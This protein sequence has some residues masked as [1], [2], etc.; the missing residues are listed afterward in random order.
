MSGHPAAPVTA[1]IL[2]ADDEPR[3]LLAVSEV[4]AAPGVELVTAGSGADALRHVLR[5]DF[6]LV[7]LDVRMPGLDGYEAAAMIRARPRSSR[8]P[9]LFMTAYN[10]DELHVFRGYSAGAVDYVFKPIEP[11]VLRSKVE[12]FVDLYRKTE[13]LKRQHAAEKQL[14]IEN[15]RVRGE[16]LNAEAALRRGEEHQSLVLRELPVALYTAALDDPGRRLRFTGEGIAAISGSPAEAFAVDGFWRSRLHPEDAGRA[17]AELR[18]LREAGQG[19][20]TVEYR[21]RH[22]DGSE[23]HVLDRAVVVPGGEEGAREVF[24]MW[25][26]VTDRREMEQRLMHASKLEAVGR[27]TGGIA[28]DFNNMLNVVIGNLDLL[29]RTVEGNDKALKRLHGAIEGA[30]RCADLTA[31]LLAFSRR[32]P[33]QAAA[34]DPAHT[35]PGIVDLLRRTLGERVEVHLE[36]EADLPAVWVDPSQFESALLN[37]AVNAR[38]AMPAGGHLRVAVS[39]LPAAAADEGP[40]Q[41]EFTVSDTGTGM[42][43][44]VL[45]RVFEPFFTTKE[46]GKGT[47]LGLSMVYGFV[48][49]SEGTIDIRSEA[50]QGTAISIRLPVCGEAAPAATPGAGAGE[51]GDPVTGEGETVLLVEDD[52]AVRQVASAALASLGFEV[53]EAESGDEAARLLDDAPDVRLVVSDVRMPG[54]LNGIDLGRLVRRRWPGVPVLLMSG[55]VDDDQD[56]SDFEFLQKPYRV[57]ELIGKLKTVLAREQV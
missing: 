55:F 38:D 37:L 51:G 29:R 46:K 41:V 14:L 43:P 22:P 57:S 24:G 27:L 7:L 2:I 19:S 34:L 3:N 56:F 33:L 8:V 32:S 15:L 25:F 35:M 18:A 12:V 54:S 53:R 36:M 52:V 40:G 9:I 23:R 44:A 31:R 50:G 30:Q 28:H 10:K 20:V 47:G 45:S 42:E 16:K 49:Q 26:D 39:H 1:K 17:A 4:L 21:W 11:V 13:E 5:E 6:A 48:Q